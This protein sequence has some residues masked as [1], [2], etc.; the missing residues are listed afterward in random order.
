MNP[1][2]RVGN[3]I[4][5]RNGTVMTAP[6]IADNAAYLVVDVRWDNGNRSTV[7]ASKLHPLGA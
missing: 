2:Q 1:G 7:Q 3:T 6:Y 5:N 4:T